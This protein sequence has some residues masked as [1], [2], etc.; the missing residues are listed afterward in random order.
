MGVTQSAMSSSLAQLRAVFEDPL[1]RRVAHGVE[2]TP[3]AVSV[4]ESIRHG[5]RLFGDALSPARFE[6]STSTRRFV[7]AASDYVEFVLLP[8]LLSRMKKDAPH[9]RL[10]VRPW[11]LHE[12]PSMLARGEADVMIGYYDGVPPRHRQELLFSEAYTCI[13]RK[14]HPRVKRRLTLA[15]W[16]EL[17][18]VLVSQR[19]ESPGS[20]DRVL[21]SRGLSRVVAARVS[22]FLLVPWLVASTDMVA[23]IGRRIAGAFAGPLGLAAHAPPLPLPTS[24]IG[25][26]WHEQMETDPAHRWLRGLIAEEARAL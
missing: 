8:R 6:P 10:E 3:R 26:V 15:T 18:H 22:H 14:G 12:V 23:A 11:G 25:Q 21:A 1:F 24:R 7:L 19:G 17:E 20:V 13:V 4:A 2:P 16:L 5:L 9:A